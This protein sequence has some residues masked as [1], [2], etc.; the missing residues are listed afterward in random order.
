MLFV[1][2]VRLGASRHVAVQ[3][4]LRSSANAGHCFECA[5]C[6][7]GGQ[8]TPRSVRGSL[9]CVEAL[10][11]HRS[12]ETPVDVQLLVSV[13]KRPT[14]QAT[15]NSAHKSIKGHTLWQSQ[16]GSVCVARGTRVQLLLSP[17][18]AGLQAGLRTSGTGHLVRPQVRRCRRPKAHCAIDCGRA[19][20]TAGAS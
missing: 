16:R 7:G 18:V 12:A 13:H 9:L 1:V 3:S 11:V 15:C 20:R 6:V 2:Q 5:W 17:V 19:S 8:R 4:V 10:E 14:Q